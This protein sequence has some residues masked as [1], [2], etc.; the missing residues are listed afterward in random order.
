MGIRGVWSK[1]RRLFSIIDPL[2]LESL[3]LGIDMFSLVYTHRACLDELL[4]LLSSWSSKGHLITCIWDGTAPK[5]KQEIIVQRREARET[6][7]DSRSELETY[8]E[9]FQADLNQQDITNLKAAIKSL[10]WQGWHLTGS[11]KRE[12]QAKLGPSVTHIYAPGEADDI[13]IQMAYE[14]KIDVILSLDSD[15]FAMGGEQIWRL[16]RFKNQWVVEDIKVEEVCNKS[17]INLSMLQDACFLAGWDR[18]HL[19]TGES[20]MPFEV[21]LNRIKHYQKL[22]VILDKFP[23]D[24]DNETLD[25]LAN[26]KRESKTRWQQILRDRNQDL[27]A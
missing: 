6:A 27:C 17:G 26:L 16:L 12:I 11:M 21:A 3:R 20:Y 23:V 10:S 15:L 8:L 5:E 2:N 19:K 7:I 13:L 1:F 25:R 4:E 22:D 24:Y 18:C 14:K 9:T